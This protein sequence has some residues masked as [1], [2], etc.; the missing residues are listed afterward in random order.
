[1]ESGSADPIER[2][3]HH[4]SRLPGIGTKSATRLAF[5]I[6]RSGELAS[7]LAE[8]LSAAS[9]QVGQCSSCGNIS[10]SDPCSVC[11]NP[12]RDPAILCVIERSQDLQAIERSGGFS[13]LFHVLG[14]VLSP[15]DGVGP[16]ELRISELLARIEGGVE[17]VIV[18]TNPTVEGD[19]TALYLARLLK[20]LGVRVSRIARGISVGAEL[21]YTDSSTL[22]RALEERRDL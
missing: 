20:P 18:A 17:E 14:G 15:L 1:M 22:S 21:E 8:A 11:S 13:G 7:E 10:S 4:L 5:H 9:V 2:L 12:K 16:E 3:V 19:A 6:L